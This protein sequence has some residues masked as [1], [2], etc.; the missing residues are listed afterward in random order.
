LTINLREDSRRHLAHEQGTIHKDWGGKVPIA[1]IYPNSYNLG[2]SNLGIHAIYSF[3]NK[4]SDT[5]CE[6]I[7]WEIQ[8]EKH[9]SPPISIE[10]Q[11]GLNEYAILAFSVTYELDYFNIPRILKASGIPLLAKDRDET[12]PLIIAGGAC[13]SANPMPL[14]PF[15]DCMCIGEAEALFPA[16]LTTWQK[17]TDCDREEQLITLAETHGILVP[18][19]PQ[20]SVTRQWVQDL[21]DFPV[22]TVITTPDTE[23]GDLYLIEVERGCPWRCRFCLVGGTFHPM[24]THSLDSILEQ[25]T[26]GLKFRKRLGLVGPDVTDHP[27]IENILI[28][29]KELK[30]EISVSS[31][32]I[33]PLCPMAIAEL[34]QGRTGTIT[35]APEAGSE[36]LR[37]VI[38]KGVVEED[39]LKAIEVTSQFAMKQL[40]LYFMIGLPT[41]TDQDIDEIIALSIK[42]KEIIE[43]KQSTVRII[44]SVSP[45]VPKAGTPFQWMP[46]EHLEVINKRLDLL[47]NQLRPVGIKVT[48]ESP[49][50]SEVQAILARGDQRL[51]PLLASM[52]T[53][54]LSAWKKA[55]REYGFNDN[56]EAHKRW[57]TDDYLP[58]DIINSGIS[59]DSLKKEL[60]SA[61]SINND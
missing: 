47:K 26:S 60:Q 2:M 38:K 43:R 52:N 17:I 35:F 8:N 16:F 4:R 54:S 27:Q 39:I 6:R 56:T 12:Y 23:L 29:L 37:K 30:A 36:R 55:L 10:S 14:A 20:K 1:L 51:A 11:R 57:D 33:R 5:I 3:L 53:T 32:R 58:W 34:A 21:D 25:A 7:F 19:V 13:I 24:R 28:K 18:Q 42:C 44:L 59:L 31:L 15:F 61:L 22:H 41:E 40:R 48:G 9:L 49:A 46:M 50:W 45:F